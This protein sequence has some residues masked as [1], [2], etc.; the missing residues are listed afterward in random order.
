MGVAADVIEHLVGPG[1]GR[2]GV[3][4]PPGLSRRLEMVGKAVGIVE[5]VERAGEVQLAR[6]E[7]LAHSV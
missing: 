2:F 4:H 5:A 3:D 6:L 7:R 1:E